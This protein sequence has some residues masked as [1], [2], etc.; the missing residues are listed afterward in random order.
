MNQAAPFPHFSRISSSVGGC[1]LDMQLL[2]PL[3]FSGNRRL[4]ALPL[5]FVWDIFSFVNGGAF[6]FRS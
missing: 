1:D 4:Y 2:L 5:S 6:G 3:F